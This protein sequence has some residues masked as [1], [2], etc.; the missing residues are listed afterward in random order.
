MEPIDV[1]PYMFL[2]LI[3]FLLIGYPVAFSLT[4]VGIAAFRR[5]DLVP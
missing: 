2:G 1:A 3:V 4:A 5:R